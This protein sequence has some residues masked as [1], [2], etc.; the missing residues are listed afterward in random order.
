MFK[1]VH[2]VSGLSFVFYHEKKS[3]KNIGKFLVC[4]MPECEMIP[5]YEY[6]CK[7][8]HKQ[9]V[10]VAWS[11]SPLPPCRFILLWSPAAGVVLRSASC[12]FQGLCHDL[13]FSLSAYMCTLI[14]ICKKKKKKRARIPKHVHHLCKAVIWTNWDTSKVNRSRQLTQS[15]GS[16]GITGQKQLRARRRRVC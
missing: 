15:R 4:N 10:S 13:Y 14:Y 16:K 11:C 2:F 8:V 1:V 3:N 5:E 9:T 6:I 12:W 7:A